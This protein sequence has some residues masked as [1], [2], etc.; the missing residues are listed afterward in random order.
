MLAQDL[1]PVPT[2]TP[3]DVS[4]GLI[5]GLVFV[6]FL[7]VFAMGSFGA[8]T[9]WLAVQRGRQWGLWFILGLIFGPVAMLAVGFAPDLGTHRRDAIVPTPPRPPAPDDPPPPPVPPPPPPAVAVRADVL[10]T[11][12]YERPRSP[13]RVEIDVDAVTV[14]QRSGQAYGRGLTIHGDRVYFTLAPDELRDLQSEL[15]RTRPVNFLV[16]EDDVV[17]VDD[18]PH[19]LRG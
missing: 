1:A 5:G 19:E 7:I 16:W 12:Q 14:H 11:T 3:V 6:V 13:A 10:E 15:E 4:D 17:D 2:P 8:F 9:G 18:L